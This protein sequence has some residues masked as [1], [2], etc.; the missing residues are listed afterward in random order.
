MLQRSEQIEEGLQKRLKES[1]RVSVT[2]R[3]TARQTEVLR[4][5]TMRVQIVAAYSE[6]KAFGSEQAAL[7]LIPGCASEG[8]QSRIRMAPNSLRSQQFLGLFCLNDNCE[9]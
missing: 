8:I 2:N 4:Y 6:P 1:G 7:R 3:E 9:A 5:P